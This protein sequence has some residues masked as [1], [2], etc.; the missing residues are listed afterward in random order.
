MSG[1]LSEGTA[2]PPGFYNPLA[3]EYCNLPP[4]YQPRYGSTTTGFIACGGNDFMDQDAL[5]N[6]EIFDPSTGT[7]SE[8]SSWDSFP[9]RY[10]HVA[11]MSS[12]GLFLIGGLGQSG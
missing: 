6:C 7:W 1:S 8:Y 5:Y 10:V 3:N 11:W 4:M 12:I 9:P 2:S